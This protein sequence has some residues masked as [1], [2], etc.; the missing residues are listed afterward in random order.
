MGYRRRRKSMNEGAAFAQRRKL[1]EERIRERDEL[2]ERTLLGLDDGTTDAALN[3]TLE[4][5]RFFEDEEEQLREMQHAHDNNERPVLEEQRRF[6][7]RWVTHKINYR[8]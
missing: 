6:R 3:E 8:R 1:N 5:D 7:E 4:F 2:I